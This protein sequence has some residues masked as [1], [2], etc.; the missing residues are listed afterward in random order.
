MRSNCTLEGSKA[1][2]RRYTTCEFELELLPHLSPSAYR[3]VLPLLQEMQPVMVRKFDRAIVEEKRA[4]AEEK[5]PIATKTRP[6]QRSYVLGLYPVVWFRSTIKSTSSLTY[7]SLCGIP[8]L[9]S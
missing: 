7:R 9:S 5:Q 1:F 4:I 2:G 8:S 3:A 6:T